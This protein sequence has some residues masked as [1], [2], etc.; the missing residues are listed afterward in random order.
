LDTSRATPSRIQIRTNPDGTRVSISRPLLQPNQESPLTT[1]LRRVCKLLSLFSRDL[2]N[3]VFV[4][5][6][7]GGRTSFKTSVD[8]VVLFLSIYL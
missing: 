7:N 2:I 6:V 3:I 5:D 1:S 4:L 8:I